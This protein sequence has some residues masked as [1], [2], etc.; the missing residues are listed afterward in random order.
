MSY[1]A[2]KRRKTLSVLDLL[3]QWSLMFI[4]VGLLV[5]SCAAAIDTHQE[6]H[7]LAPESRAA[8]VASWGR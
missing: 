3:V 8:V 6:Q 4:L 7:E 2:R 1:Y 5:H